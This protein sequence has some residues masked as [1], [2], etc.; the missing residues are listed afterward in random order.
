MFPLLPPDL[1]SS[2]EALVRTYLKA[3]Q[4]VS[5][6]VIFCN[7]AQCCLSFTFNSGFA[8]LLSCHTLCKHCCKQFRSFSSEAV[9]PSDHGQTIRWRL[10]HHLY[11]RLSGKISTCWCKLPLAFSRSSS[12]VQFLSLKTCTSALGCTE[13]K[14][15]SIVSPPFN[16]AGQ[17]RSPFAIME[18][19]RSR[20]ALLVWQG[21]LPGW[22]KSSQ[23]RVSSYF[24]MQIS[25]SDGEGVLYSGVVRLVG[26]Q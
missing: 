3:S 1:P 26:F 17:I 23:S 20:L 11:S 19:D 13:G 10:W 14:N 6:N 18:L 7:R 25:P 4:Q 12:L 5:L 8:A 24:C 22:L 21:W 9:C 16:E 15:P 2:S